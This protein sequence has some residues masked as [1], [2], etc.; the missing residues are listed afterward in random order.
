MEFWELTVPVSA[1]ASESVT[2]FLW[3]QGAL[4]VVEELPPAAPRLRA[5]FSAEASSA[6]L[7]AAVGRFVASLR[8]L[9]IEGPADP[10]ALARL[11]DEAWASAWQR[12]FP[13][14]PVGERLLVLPPWERDTRADGRVAIVIEPGRAFGTGHHGSTEGCLILLDALLPARRVGRVLDV[15]TGTGILAIAA[16]TL[17][18]AEAVAVDTDP[19]AIAAAAGNARRNGCAERIR[20]SLG[21]PE[22]VADAGPFEL[23]LANLLA[24]THTALAAAYRSLLAPGGALVLGGLLAEED[25]AVQALLRSRG[26]RLD[27]RVVVD[28]WSSLLLRAGG[29]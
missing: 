28:G 24:H 27:R 13:P 20:L 9:G 4:G 19:D 16:V 22:A 1:A 15:G 7:L 26:L 2:N 6:G 12:A 10:P 29:A 11:R 8:E 3:E 23:V 21:G 25:E 18:A 14:R 17:G 5:F